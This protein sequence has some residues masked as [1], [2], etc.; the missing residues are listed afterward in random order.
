M[1][2]KRIDGVAPAG[3]VKGIGSEQSRRNRDQHHQD[4][5][6]PEEQ[7]EHQ[8]LH[9]LVSL[10]SLNA[11]EELVQTRIVRVEQKSEEEAEKHPHFD[12]MV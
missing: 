12:R 11:V 7:A 5:E 3:R 8:E 10:A 2:F 6:Q 1:D 4:E 9:D